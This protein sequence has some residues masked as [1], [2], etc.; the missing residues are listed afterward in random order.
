MCYESVSFIRLWAYSAWRIYWPLC[1]PKKNSRCLIHV[2]WEREFCQMLSSHMKCLCYWTKFGP[3]HPHTSTHNGL[4]WRKVHIYC[5]M[6]CKENGKSVVKRS[7]FPKGFHGKDFKGSVGEGATRCVI[8]PC[9][10]LGLL[11][12]G[13]SFMHHQPSGFN[14]SRVYVAVSPSLLVGVCFL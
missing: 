5:R 4:W 12:S 2:L 13:W 11:A 7:E 9:T 6:P 14:Q 8:S 3:A 10:I 1:P